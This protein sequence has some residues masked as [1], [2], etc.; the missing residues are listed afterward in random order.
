MDPDTRRP[1]EP[2]VGKEW[3]EIEMLSP[4][5]IEKRTHDGTMRQTS[6]S[7]LKYIDV[8]RRPKPACQAAV[9]V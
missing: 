1:P 4:E 7:A 8:A 9:G 2:V 6:P 3:W 5:R